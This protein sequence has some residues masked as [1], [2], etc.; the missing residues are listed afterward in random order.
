MAEGGDAQPTAMPGP[1]P[2]LKRLDRFV[3][4]W[5]M[6]GTRSIPTRTT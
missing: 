4:T 1:D 2:E 5:N 3:G 6:K